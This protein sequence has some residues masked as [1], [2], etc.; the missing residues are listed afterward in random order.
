[1]DIS[2][3][4]V[5][6]SDMTRVHPAKSS[7]EASEGW[8]VKIDTEQKEG[9]HLSAVDSKNEVK[10]MIEMHTIEVMNLENKLRVEETSNIKEVL[11]D[12]EDKKT[13]AIEVEKET[14][15]KLLTG[16]DEHTKVDTVAKSAQRLEEVLATIEEEKTEAVENVIERLVDKRLTAKNEL[17]K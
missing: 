6:H 9:T 7:V 10:Q 3:L 1:M 13:K 2:K 17:M 11:A 4:N 8:G 5:E 12:Y 16:S 14:L 15:L